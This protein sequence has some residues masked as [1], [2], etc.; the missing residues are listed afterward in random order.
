MADEDEDEGEMAVDVLANDM[1]VSK[2][3][4]TGMVSVIS[5]TSDG[6]EDQQVSGSGFAVALDPLSGTSILDTNFPL[7]T[8]FSIWRGE[9]LQNVTGP[10]P[11]EADIV[12][13][14]AGIVVIGA[15]C[16]RNG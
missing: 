9:T 1:L 15:A 3:G 11:A 16:R 13:I 10:L 12:I 6:I 5:S 14:G 8:T 7:G 2:L 4:A